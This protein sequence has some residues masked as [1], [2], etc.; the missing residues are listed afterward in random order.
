MGGTGDARAPISSCPGLS[1][2][3]PAIHVAAA[4]EERRGCPGSSPGMAWR[5]LSRRLRVQFLVPPE[6]AAFVEGDTAVACEIGFDVGPRGDTVA[7]SNQSWD[8]F[9]ERLH[10]IGERIAQALDDLKQREVDIGR[11]APGDVRGA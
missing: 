5:E 6:D 7:Q 1:W 9:L 3:G 8:V 10:P 2:T 4:R 11:L